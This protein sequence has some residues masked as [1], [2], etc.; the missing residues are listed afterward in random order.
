MV[1]S[2]GSNAIGA[3]FFP[4]QASAI[5]LNT[6]SSTQ[7]SE[8]VHE[9]IIASEQRRSNQPEHRAIILD[10]RED[11]SIYRG[12]LT[13]TA[14]K[15][16]HVDLSHRIPIDNV[17]FSK[18]DKKTFGELF[19]HHSVNFPGTISAPTFIVPDYGNSPPYFSASIPFVA[20]GLQL[21]SPKGEPFVAVYE[22]SAEIVKPTII[23]H[24]ENALTN[25]STNN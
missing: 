11:G 7:E 2:L 8:I 6:T 25:T 10:Y 13:F 15:A 9:G 23:N 22:V 14:T 20:S 3:S 4:Q 17:T 12:V 21:I 1:Q 18:I 19:L 5:H 16:V 24:I